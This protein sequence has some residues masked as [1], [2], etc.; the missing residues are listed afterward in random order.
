MSVVVVIVVLVAV[1][2]FQQNIKSMYK[3]C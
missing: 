2:I 1:V 3:Q